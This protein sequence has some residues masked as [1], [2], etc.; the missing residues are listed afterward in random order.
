MARYALVIGI[1]QYKSPL[2]N[3][4]KT[5]IDAE[6]VAQILEKCGD[7]EKVTR[8]PARLNPE[9]N[10]YEMVSRGVTGA[11][12]GQALKTFFLE[13]ADKS[14]ALIYFTGHGLTVSDHLGQKKG[15]L[16][17][18][19]CVIE[20]QGQEIVEQQHGIALDSLNDLIRASNLSNLVLLLDCCHGGYFL[21][22]SLVEQTL[23]AFSSQRDYYL[24]TACRGFEQAWAIK[25]EQ[26]DVFTGALLK[27]LAPENAGRDGRISGDRLFDYISS[28]LKDSRQ[29]PIRMGWGRSIKLITYPIQQLPTL[30]TAPSF[31]TENPYLGLNAF[32][33]EQADY[34]CGREQI[35]RVL[36]DHLRK[37]RFLAVI[38]PSGCGKSSLVKAGLFPL[39]K[40]NGLPGSSQWAIEAFTPGNY[41]IARL[42]ETLARQQQ[43]SEPFVLFI[44]QFEELFTLCGDD[45]E[46]RDFIRLM[47]QEATNSE[48]PTKVIIAIRGDFIDRCAAYP[49]AASLIN[50][51][52][53]NLVTPLTLLELNE[54]IEKPASLHGVTL[55]SGLVSQIANDVVDRPGALPLLQYALT[56]LW[57]V[58][59]EE[60]ESAQPCLTWHGYRE[61][62]GVKG[63]LEK[64]AD[65]LYLSFSPED[66]AFVR[67][68]LLELVQIGEGQKFTR[69]RSSWEDLRAIAD[70][71]E[72]LDRVTRRLSDQQQRLIITSDKTVEVAHEALFSEWKLLHDWI[73]ES[74]ED[75]QL[76]RRLEAACQDWQDIYQQSEDALLTGAPLAAIEAWIDK[77]QPKL[78]LQEAE[79]IRKSVE[80]RDREN[81]AQLEQERRLRE[82]A[83]ARAKEYQ[84]RVK[85]EK[86]RTQ[87]ATTFGVLL[88]IL[89][90]VSGSLAFSAQTEKRNAQ[91]NE[92]KALTATS[93]A[94]FDAHNQL[95]SLVAAVKTLKQIQLKR[96]QPPALLETIVTETQEY[97][98]L[99]GHK[100]DT[101]DADFAPSGDIIGSTSID[102]T[103]KIWK[104]NGEFIRDIG[105]F[106]KGIWGIDF[107]SDSQLIVTGSIDGVA[108][109]WGIKG[110]LRQELRPQKIK[111]RDAVLKVRF[112]PN[113]SI[114][115]SANWDKTVKLW[116]VSDGQLLKSFEHGDPV[117]GVDFSPNGEIIVSG[118]WD[119]TVKLWR[120]S[121]GQ[122]LKSFEHKDRVHEVAFSPK[123]NLVASASWDKTVKLW[124]VSDGELHSNL[125]H[126]AAVYGVSFSPTGTMVASASED[127]TIKLWNVPAGK[128]VKTFKGHNGPV[129]AIN[130][131]PDGKL[132]VSTSDDRTV[133]VWG[134]RS[135]QPSSYE[136]NGLINASCIWLNDYLSTNVN[137]ANEDRQICDR[138]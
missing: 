106:Q 117:Y 137:I 50:Q 86:Q 122:L 59:I 87:I 45:K 70:S 62:G 61:I 97:N 29:E 136:T 96:V 23:T 112:S 18:S 118:S 42:L 73:E 103:V 91:V 115:A 58:C 80:K 120:V 1:A 11:E 121:D 69:R 79:F 102:R 20:A 113:N 107:S 110:D 124:R 95:D 13:R 131:S 71:P 104:K 4:D 15:Y 89:A 35:V 28:E 57:R 44:D 49:E 78:P 48:R 51:T 123:G 75:I 129:S 38:G 17:T 47:S 126:D 88:A 54:A 40:R 33:L 22:R 16:A 14:E 21:E 66:Q 76:N 30:E 81:Q 114:V 25:T 9:N 109:V 27:G 133:R 64:R 46:R 138:S 39:F 2:K 67:R 31:K 8:L 85:A 93:K 128:L 101:I 32:A 36:I 43:R 77:S 37:S 3:L 63:A 56:E 82:E 134:L 60:V 116:R 34:F 105:S 7:F 119:K 108:R 127:G 55:E 135:I 52:Q 100:Q 24:I 125:K 92:I 132:L 130:F 84:G 72:Q 90:A 68:L 111:E 19:D 5:T 99:E 83:E 12:L 10:V 26:H 98:R 6:A 94:L 65:L 74:R 41:P 53:P